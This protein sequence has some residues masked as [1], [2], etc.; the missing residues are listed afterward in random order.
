MS[1]PDIGCVLCMRPEPHSHPTDW[2]DD[3]E[4]QTILHVRSSPYRGSVSDAALAR[5]R[6][7]LEAQLDA[8]IAE[9]L[10]CDR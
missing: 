9:A 8:L 1:F 5:I 10:V 7:I 4:R 3:F 6:E 2:C